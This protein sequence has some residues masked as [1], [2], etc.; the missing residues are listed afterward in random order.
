LNGCGKAITTIVP[1][2]RDKALF[3]SCMYFL[4]LISLAL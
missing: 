2:S 1:Q 4:V 3:E